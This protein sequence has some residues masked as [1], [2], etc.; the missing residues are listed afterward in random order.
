MSKNM[1]PI[2]FKIPEH[3]LIFRQ[4]HNG[5]WYDVYGFRISSPFLIKDELL[6][7]LN[8]QCYKE[9]A[10][11]LNSNIF[12]NE[13][14]DLV[15]VGKIVYDLNLN[16]INYLGQKVSKLGSFCLTIDNNT[17]QEVFLN[18]SKR[19]FIMLPNFE[20]YELN[21]EKITSYKSLFSHS[22]FKAHIFESANETFWITHD[23]KK[24]L[25]IENNILNV[26]QATIL[27]FDQNLI[28]KVSYKITPLK[29]F[30][31]DLFTMKTWTIP[32]LA[33]KSVQDIDSKT[34][35]VGGKILRNIVIDNESKVYDQSNHCLYT[36]DGIKSET[37][38]IEDIYGFKNLF[39]N[40]SHNNQN[41]VFNKSTESFL[42]INDNH[43]VKIFGVAQD[44]LINAIDEIGQ[45][46]VLDLRKGVEN[47]NQAFSNKIP[48]T[49]ISSNKYKLGPKILQEAWIFSLGGSVKRYIDLN[50]KDLDVFTLPKSLKSYPEQN[51]DSI[52]A[53]MVIT[54]IVDDI[55]KLDGSKFRAAKFLS[56]SDEYISVIL[57]ESNGHPLHIVGAGHRNELVTGF[58]NASDISNISSNKVIGT[59]T[60]TEDF[61]N[62]T[63][64][65][66]LSKNTSW[67]PFFDTFLPI[68]SRKVTLNE[69]TDWDYI[70]FQLRESIKE[71]EYIVV[72]KNKPH[73]LLV[74]KKSG[75]IVPKIVKSSNS[76]LRIPEEISLIKKLFLDDPG[77]LV[78]LK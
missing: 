29:T 75:T 71:S 6:I 74:E 25:S 21:N 77:F 68:L 5:I 13:T 70:L 47:I 27:K 61:K 66:S 8:G 1:K 14:N 43:I 41:F 73:R 9:A 57:R 12:S 26:H 30:Y 50:K 46:F 59:Q 24:P 78:E 62:S 69:S 58:N 10:A 44:K 20:P 35:K 18:N 42:R 48:I 2:E 22:G 60:I 38:D 67:I 4:D 3:D 17:V 45:E 36:F 37:F 54:N 19:R 53:G 32:K 49:K 51:K 52:F 7:S 76:L 31:I 72:E 15:Q 65:Y 23:L 39:C 40:V 34:V 16:P 28:A 33:S 56:F 11:F 64:L 55:I 63:L